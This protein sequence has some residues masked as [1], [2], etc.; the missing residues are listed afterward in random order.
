MK[1]EPLRNHYI[2][3]ESN[4][5]TDLEL[6]IMLIIVRLRNRYIIDENNVPREA[7]YVRRFNDAN[8]RFFNPESQ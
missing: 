2:A 3:A 7:V 6:T 1:F 8:L 5:E 4:E